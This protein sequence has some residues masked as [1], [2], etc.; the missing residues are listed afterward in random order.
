MLGPPR[1]SLS[2]CPNPGFHRHRDGMGALVPHRRDACRETRR[3]AKQGNCSLTV[4]WQ[5]TPPS[6]QTQ[7]MRCLQEDVVTGQGVLGS[8]AQQVMPSWEG[9]TEAGLLSKAERFL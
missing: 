1:D 5:I 9:A 8:G 7:Q 4:T 2:L 3:Q 6:Q